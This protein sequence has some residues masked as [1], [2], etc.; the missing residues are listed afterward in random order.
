MAAVPYINDSAESP[1]RIRFV[2]NITTDGCILHNTAGHH[3]HVFCG[4]CQLLDDK[5]YHLSEG[6]IFV[7]E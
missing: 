1:Y 5:V 4:V 6:G 2:E 3:D 7:L